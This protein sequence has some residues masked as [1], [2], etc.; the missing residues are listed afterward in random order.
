MKFNKIQNF[1]IIS[2]LLSTISCAF[3]QR[4]KVLFN[5]SKYIVIYSLVVNLLLGII[6]CYSFT[7]ISFPNSLWV[8]LFS[9][10]GA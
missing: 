8:G 9:F 1:L 4:T 2:V 5:S 3:V 7:N 10:L 6:F